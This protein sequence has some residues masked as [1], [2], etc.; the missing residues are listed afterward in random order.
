MQNYFTNCLD[1]IREQFISHDELADQSIPFLERY[2]AR[3]YP[4]LRKL[5]I[6]ECE[7]VYLS[8]QTRD[9][10]F[11]TNIK[12]HLGTLDEMSWGFKGTGP[13]TLA[14]NILYTFT[15][16][17]MFSRVNAIEFREE[18]L[19]KLG[20]KKSYW[21]PSSMI[22]DWIEKKQQGGFDHVQ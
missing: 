3:H 20:S 17:S 9:C 10:R 11:N 4:N 7:D 5:E 8:G 16:D 15:G 18:F 22:S 6:G 21:L 19:E 2:Y 13:H 14:V 12:A 1:R